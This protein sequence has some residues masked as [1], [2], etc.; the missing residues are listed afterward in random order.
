MNEALI[1]RFSVCLKSKYLSP[2]IEEKV[3]INKTG[4]R[5]EAAHNMVKAANDIRNGFDKGDLTCTMSLRSLLS[6]AKMCHDINVNRPNEFAEHTIINQIPQNER[7]EVRKIV[8]ASV[9]E[10]GTYEDEENIKN[11]AFKE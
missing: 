7:A 9:G 2:S 4:I 8:E 5:K 11:T 6:W 3:I 1:D 10:D